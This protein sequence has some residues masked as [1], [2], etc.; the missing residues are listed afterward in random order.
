VDTLN[1]ETRLPDMMPFLPSKGEHAMLDIPFVVGIDGRQFRGERLSLVMAE[2]TGLMDPALVGSTRVTR[3]VF[4]F[5][6]FSVVLDVTVEIQSI[7]REQ[8]RATLAFT[9]PG[10][11]HL[12]QMRHIL[13]SYIAGDLV[14]LGDVISIGATLPQTGKRAPQPKGA[15]GLTI[16]RLIGSLGFAL[17]TLL[18]VG[19]VA[20]LAY[21]RVFTTPILSAGRVVQDGMTLTALSSG[22]IDYV[23]PAAAKGE[24]A[25]SLRTNGGEQLSVAMPCDCSAQLMGQVA[26]AT[27]QAGTPVMRVAQADAPI[28]VMA[29]VLPLEM[30]NL[31]FA[32]H[33][34][35]RF[36]NGVIVSAKF[37][38]ASLPTTSGGDTTPVRLL[39]DAALDAALIGQLAE[40]TM[41]RKLPFVSN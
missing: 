35:M 19:I 16:R 13:N 11:A 4:P 30:R 5:K 24:V 22:Q 27:V 40:L 38:L 1:A 9:E 18:L 3:L 26:G 41:V 21:T 36:S 32:D 12:P 23:N 2:V 34:N 14:A 7:D 10:G 28:V 39:P 8:G 15:T 25:F 17:A 37:D 29:D 6:G 33:V 20:S 31:A